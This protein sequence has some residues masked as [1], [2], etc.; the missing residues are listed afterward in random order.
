MDE[1]SYL[2]RSLRLGTR[3]SAVPSVFLA[4]CFS[5]HGVLSR[6]GISYFINIY[7][8]KARASE[9]RLSSMLVNAIDGILLMLHNWF[10][11]LMLLLVC[12]LGLGKYFY[13]PQFHSSA[14]SFSCCCRHRHRR[15]WP[16][17]NYASMPSFFSVFSLYFW[18]T[19]DDRD[20]EFDRK[21]A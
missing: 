8:D 14:F 10:D 21:V 7:S 16:K 9:E 15:G 12:V 6:G 1:S 19:T 20:A 4:L 18:E 3:P 5:L 2:C 13:S 11:H 17:Y